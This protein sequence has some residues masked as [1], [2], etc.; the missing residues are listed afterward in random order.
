MTVAELGRRVSASEMAEWE[1][2]ARLEPIGFEMH[3]MLA[4]RICQAVVSPYSKKAPKL[5]TWMLDFLYQP[6]TSAEIMSRFRAMV[7]SRPKE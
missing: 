3:N 4:A 5:E 1:I 2:Y 7:Q 6:P